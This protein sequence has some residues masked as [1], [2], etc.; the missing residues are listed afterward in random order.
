MN[1]KKCKELRRI[2]KQTSPGLEETKYLVLRASTLTHRQFTLADC[3]RG[4]YQQ[5]KKLLKKKLT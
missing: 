3:Q 2:T 4:R 5:M 1:A